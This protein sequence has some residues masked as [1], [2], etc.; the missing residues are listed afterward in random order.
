MNSSVCVSHLFHRV[1]VLLL[2]RELSGFVLNVLL[3]NLTPP[4]SNISPMASGESLK[5]LKESL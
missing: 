3:D 1:C 5:E 4:T 2:Y